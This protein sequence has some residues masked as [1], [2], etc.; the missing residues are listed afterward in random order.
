[1]KQEARKKERGE[2]NKM[3]N[4]EGERAL[5]DFLAGVEDRNGMEISI[6]GVSRRIGKICR[7]R[8]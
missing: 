7:G 1:M 4:K 3:E 5:I 6:V 8:V 2:K